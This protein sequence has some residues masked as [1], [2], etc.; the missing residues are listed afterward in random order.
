[1]YLGTGLITCTY[2]LEWVVGHE[3]MHMC[4]LVG[5]CVT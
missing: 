3:Y 1:V 5:I 2:V 4:V